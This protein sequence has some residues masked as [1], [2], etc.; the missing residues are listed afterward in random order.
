MSAVSR[1][2]RLLAERLTSHPY[3]RSG[4]R[5]ETALAGRTVIVTGGN[6]NIGRAISLAF[7][8]EG[9]NVVIVARDEVQGRNVLRQALECGASDAFWYAADVTDRAQM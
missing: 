3:Q 8:T 9:A 7:A 1:Q 5:M 6:S 2:V 4:G